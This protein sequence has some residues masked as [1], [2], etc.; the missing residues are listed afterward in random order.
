MTIYNYLVVKFYAGKNG[1]L[2]VIFTISH[3]Q[4]I[5]GIQYIQGVIVCLLMSGDGAPVLL[6]MV[7]CG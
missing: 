6:R 3:M 7:F 4:N 1:R 2:Q 5:N